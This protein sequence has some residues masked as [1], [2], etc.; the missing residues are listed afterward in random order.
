[1]W[2]MGWDV[3]IVHC[4]NEHLVDTNYWSLLDA[5]L[6]YD[7]S[8]CQYLH[9]FKD[10]RC[11]PSVPTEIPMDVEHMPYYW[12]HDIPHLRNS[13]DVGNVD[14]HSISKVQAPV[15]VVDHAGATIMAQTVTLGDLGPTYLSH[16]SVQSSIFSS[17]DRPNTKHVSRVLYNSELT[18]IAYSTSHFPWAVYGFNSRHFVSTIKQHNLPFSIVLACNPYAHSRALFHEVTKC[19]TV[20]PTAL[21]PSWTTSLDLD[22][23]AQLMGT[24]STLTNINQASLPLPS[25]CFRHLLWSSCKSSTNCVYSLPSS[26]RTT[27]DAASPNL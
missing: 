11:N 23:Q 5:D 12:G 2:L 26:I 27:T 25:G 10:L 1:M 24:W 22:T 9:L 17:A 3:D 14:A 21:V 6:C 8:F 4:H 15:D 16:H 19:P 20:L 13:F 7:P 18:S